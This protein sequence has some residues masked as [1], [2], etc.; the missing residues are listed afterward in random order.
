VVLKSDPAT[1]AVSF[2]HLIR[3]FDGGLATASLGLLC[4]FVIVVGM[5][6]MLSELLNSFF[7]RRLNVAPDAAS[8]GLAGVVFYVLD[9]VDM[10]I[11]VWAVLGFVVAVT[12]ARV[13]GS[14]RLSVCHASIADGGD[15]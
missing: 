7:K 2:A 12:V 11:G 1:L 10:L 13:L 14:I 15:R 4:H 6:A 5:A 9:Q 8:Y 3:T